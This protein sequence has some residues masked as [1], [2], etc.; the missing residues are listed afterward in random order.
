MK[1]ISGGERAS[2][3]FKNVLHTQV[4]LY[5]LRYLPEGKKL[6]SFV[7]YFMCQFLK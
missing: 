7:K 4:L 5:G 2:S 6:T 1:Q 3:K